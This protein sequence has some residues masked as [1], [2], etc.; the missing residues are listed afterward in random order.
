MKISRRD[1]LIGTL[2][3]SASSLSAGCATSTKSALNELGA[4][5]FAHGVASGDPKPTG[6]IIWTRISPAAPNSNLGVKWEVSASADFG[7]ILKSGI[8]TAKPSSD[9]TVK[10][11]LSGLKAGQQYFYRFHTNTQTSPI[12]KFKTLPIGNVE[13]AHFAVVSCS[14][15]PF[16]YFHAYDHIAKQGELDAVIH[17]GD[18]I[19]EYGTAGYGGKTGEKLGR[20]H[21]PAHEILTLEDYRARHAQYK[22]DTA[23]KA[24]HAAH[25]FIPVWD[26]HETANNSWE[27]GAENHTSETEGD[28]EERRR[29]ALQAYYE[30][31]P[32]A[33]PAAGHS[34]EQFFK[35]YE[36]GDLLTLATIETRLTARSEQLDYKNVL[37]KI[38]SAQD[39]T[40]FQENVLGS[41]DRYMLG[42]KQ[43][44]Y[45]SKTLRKSKRNKK[46][47][48]VI[49]NQI[50][51]A[52]VI[53]PDMTAFKDTQAIKELEKT[54]PDV[55]E[56]LAF[57]ALGL[58]LNLDA[59]DGYPAAREKLFETAAQANAR[60][61]LVLTG[62]THEFWANEL[63]TKGGAKAGIEL[64]TGGVTSPGSATYFGEAAQTFSQ[65]LVS[66]NDMVKYH[67]PSHKGYM[68]LTMTPNAT[69]V[70]FIS[71]GD[72]TKPNYVAKEIATFTINPG[73]N[74]SL[75]QN[76]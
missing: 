60:D 44:R 30:W 39:M 48:R 4:G 31:M 47:W 57:T 76:S 18:Y 19:Y 38:K 12:G 11:L 8:Y 69:N 32:V 6:M 14:N 61:L 41:P 54:W 50:I 21:Q 56:F 34:P 70:K 72:I 16:G 74:L 49:C 37:P 71:V 29:A 73:E 15:F 46:P 7:R 51:M 75:N 33:D 59:W 23:S 40:D 28:W 65:Q 67:D 68:R 58:P 52:E 26:D 20:K 35:S 64:G 10:I 45:L 25:A 13:S 27:A 53:A 24:M 62:D 1:A 66:G 43:L 42:D 3:G 55:K 2:V 9:W 63:R 5:T 22:V 17:L 36:W